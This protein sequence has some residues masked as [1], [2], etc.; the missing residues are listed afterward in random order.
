MLDDVWTR[1]QN[2]ARDID[3]PVPPS[4]ISRRSTFKER[5]QEE[6]GSFYQFFQPLN[7][8]NEQR[9]MLLI[10][11]KTSSQISADKFYEE[12]GACDLEIPEYQLEGDFKSLVHAALSL[13]S[14]LKS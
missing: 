4:F 8:E 12:E 5:L 10:P 1:F 2:L 3:V 14:D 6:V 11:T 7:R 9:Q 13:R